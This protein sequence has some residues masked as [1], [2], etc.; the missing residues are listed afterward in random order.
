MSWSG[1]VTNSP[2]SGTDVDQSIEKA[3]ESCKNAWTPEE[4]REAHDAAI[5]AQLDCIKAVVDAVGETRVVSVNFHGH[6]NADGSGS[7]GL[8]GNL[9]V[10]VPAAEPVADTTS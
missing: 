10:T 9:G 1:T 7:F 6:L 3:R 4:I 5:D 2:E 8:S